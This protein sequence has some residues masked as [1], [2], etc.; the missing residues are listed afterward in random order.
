VAGSSS[1]TG[2]RRGTDLLDGTVTLPLILAA[3][4]DRELADLDLRGVSVPEDAER[5]CDRIAATG[6]PV[7]TRRRATQL[8]STAKADLDGALD[9]KTVG[10]LH[11]VADRIVDR[12]S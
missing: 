1:D 3:E 12:A 2:K 6:A 9:P 11:L 8:V 5:I 10:L 7:E 4:I